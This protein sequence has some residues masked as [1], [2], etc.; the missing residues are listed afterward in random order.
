MSRTLN[1]EDEKDNGGR[2]GGR[3]QADAK[4]CLPFTEC[5]VLAYWLN[6]C[7]P[8]LKN[9]LHGALCHMPV[10]SVARR[11]RQESLLKA[12]HMNIY[13]HAHANIHAGAARAPRSVPL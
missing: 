10:I 6:V 9:Y 5:M 2:D 11:K 12:T 8:C 1:D 7:E 3:N 13:I 4:P